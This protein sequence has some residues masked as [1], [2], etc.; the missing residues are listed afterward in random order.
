LPQST[1]FWFGLSENGPSKTG[2]PSAPALLE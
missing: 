2:H 1:Q